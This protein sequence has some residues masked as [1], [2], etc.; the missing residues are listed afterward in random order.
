MSDLIEQL[1]AVGLTPE[2]AER[3][4]AAQAETGE[5]LPVVISRIG[6]LPDTDVVR[7]L[8][9]A[10]GLP[11]VESEDRLED[12]PETRLTLSLIHI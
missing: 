3:A 6:L 2:S 10:H 11:E 8:S 5:P 7:A 4:R 9:S 1:H 12:L